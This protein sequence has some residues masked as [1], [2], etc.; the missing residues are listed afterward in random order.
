MSSFFF[1]FLSKLDD[2]HWLSYETRFRIGREPPGIKYVGVRPW[3][4]VTRIK[5]QLSNE[6]GFFFF[7]HFLCMCLRTL[8]IRTRRI[9]DFSKAYC[10]AF[11]LRNAL[12]FWKKEDFS[13]RVYFP[14]SIMEDS[15][16]HCVMIFEKK[17]R[18]VL[19]CCFA[20][21][22]ENSFSRF[23]QTNK[24]LERERAVEKIILVINITFVKI[25]SNFHLSVR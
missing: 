21:N 25:K 20:L 2:A 4:Y 19:L 12:C 10:V 15:A 7:V 16:G 13:V 23:W 18:E 17:F 11:L 9:Y 3:L 1:F 5:D 8:W 14:G 6:F 24:V 22:R